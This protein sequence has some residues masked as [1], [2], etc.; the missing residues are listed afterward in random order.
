MTPGVH[1]R[2]LDTFP[3]PLRLHGEA[4]HSFPFLLESALPREGPRP[5]TARYDL[6]LGDPVRT[7]TGHADGR[8]DLDGRAVAGDFLEVLGELR[9]QCERGPP[10][11]FP[12]P[13]WG[14]FFVY[15]GYEL[16]GHLE[17]VPGPKGEP[18]GP[19]AV[20]VEVVSGVIRD[21]HTRT[22][23]A[24]SGADEAPARCEAVAHWAEAA[25]EKPFQ[26]HPLQL[27][28]PREA[29]PEAYLEG[30]RRAREYIHA[31]DVFQVNLARAWAVQ[32]QEPPDPASVY[33][34]LRRANP[35]PFAGIARLPDGTAI[36]SSS[37]ERLVRVRGDTAETRPIAGTRPRSRSEAEDRRLSLELKGNPKERAEH[38]MLIDLERNDLGRVCV[39]GSVEVDELMALETY[40]HVHHITSNVGG[41]LA[42]GRGS[43]EAL[44][45]LF[46]GG[47]ITGCPKV[48]C[49]Q[50]IHEL[51]PRP[52]GPYTGS[53]GYLCYDGS[54]DVNILIRTLVQT[55]SHLEF[56]TGAGIVADSVPERELEETRA[57]ARGLLS[58]LGDD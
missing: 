6:L 26:A 5:G 34:R 36:V 39:P 29:A 28:R 23:M 25:S 43:E 12:G 56:L 38:V 33:D 46:P 2:H 48:R 11:G 4:P 24:F 32:A 8:L 17:P 58:A 42:P 15:L 27:P 30:V 9:A 53:M 20:A 35:A 50:I 1:W 3:D 44:R 45:A 55:G 19:V 31:G 49:M 10:K 37:P 22:A 16:A 47:T 52:R 18:V 7:L 13:F 57:K 51:E 14:G 54:L 41:R 40:A 21:H